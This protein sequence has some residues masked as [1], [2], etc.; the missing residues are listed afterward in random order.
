MAELSVEVS[1]NIDK[2]SRELK[3]AQG[4]LK[5]MGS[6]ADKNVAKLDKPLANATKGV[7]KLGKATAVNANP[8]LQEF[9]RVI[10][11]APFGIMG[12]GNNITQL[13]GNFGNLS[14]S[15]GGA[16]AAFKAMLGS[17]AG[18]GGILLAVSAAVTI[19][20]VFGD[21]I[22]NS[23]TAAEKLAETTKKAAEAL[24]KYA[25]SLSDVARATVKGQQSAASEI[26]TL[27]LLRGQIENTTLTTE[28]RKDG[29]LKLRKEF[30]AYFQDVK[31]EQLLNGQA[32]SSYDTLTN[33]IIKRAKATAAQDLLVQNA[34]KEIALNDQINS[35]KS[36]VLGKERSLTK[37]LTEQEKIQNAINLGF[38]GTDSGTANKINEVS[39]QA[40]INK[41]TE[42]KIELE[43][44]L[45]TITKEN[46]KLSAF[47][48][49]NVIVEPKEIK[50]DTSNSTISEK[51]ND[52]FADLTI[53]PASLVNIENAIPEALGRGVQKIA[54][55][56]SEYQ[57]RIQE[58]LNN[59]NEAAGYIIEDGL[60]ETFAGIGNAIGGALTSGGN[61]LGALGASLLGSLGGL[62][63]EMGKMAITIGVGLLG[64]KA[65]LK[66]LNPAAAIGAGIA[67]IA[68]GGVFSSASKG[69]SDSIGGGGSGVGGQGS[70]GS[71]F[72]TSGGG[73]AGS[74]SSGDGTVVFEIAGTKLVGVLSRTLDRNKRLG[75]NLSLT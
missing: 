12:V 37:E 57:L 69:L 2:L 62:M 67:L 22:F 4:E 39:V 64:I 21:K 1:A 35:I 20:T 9:S 60:A 31:D 15:A 41:L 42:K 55:I 30:P 29:I 73:G 54:P 58:G 19:L 44:Q 5:Q 18:P 68:L 14:K 48:T 32:A 26:T 47:V 16:G 72:A 49:D 33:S 70:G 7:N 63:V 71:S 50:L 38:A 36:E 6:A 65:A 61:I 24:D 66:S 27:K 34:K 10:Q 17:L 46:T 53:Q 43:K 13:V 11:D 75:G 56:M 8:A 52:G 59:L 74:F 23:K 25:D 40:Q 28:E 3:K 45:G 51:V